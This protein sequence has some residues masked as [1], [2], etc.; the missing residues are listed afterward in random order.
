MA[1]RNIVQAPRSVVMIRPHEFYANPQTAGDNG[2]QTA[3]N[4]S[5][6]EMA[7]AAL[8]EHNAAQDQLRE[9]GVQVHVFDDHGVGDTPDSVFP[10]NWFSTHSFHSEF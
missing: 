6:K 9:A 7:E 4:F 10:N 5:R 3:V 8:R 2:F 1:M